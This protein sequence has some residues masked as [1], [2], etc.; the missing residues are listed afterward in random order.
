MAEKKWEQTVQKIE[1]GVYKIKLDRPEKLNAFTSIMYHELKHGVL[2][3]GL[4]PDVD[5]ILIE[6]SDGAFATGGDLEEFLSI[7]ELPAHEFIS[8]FVSRFDEPIPFRAILECPKPVVAKIDGICVAGGLLIATTCDV[9]IATPRST[10]S[11]PEGKVGLADPYCATILPLSIGVG[12]ARYMTMT[13]DT[14]DAELA[15]HWGIIH[16]V[17]QRDQIDQEVDKVLERLRRISPE[18]RRAYK[19]VINRVIPHMSTDAL[20]GPVMS[21][22]GREGLKA[23]VEKRAPNWDRATPLT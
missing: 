15:H 8:E 2:I 5:S 7:A 13:A 11:V 3:G 16:K 23:F 12:R 1:N 6:G 4:H 20:I 19:Q 22:N 17:V 18:S 21:T 10:F 14:I 9:A